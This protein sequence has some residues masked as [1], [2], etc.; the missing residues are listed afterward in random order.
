[1]Y[2]Y[3]S[4]LYVVLLFTYTMYKIYISSRHA[5]TIKKKLYAYLSDI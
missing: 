3:A 4:M 5:Q 1:M 2:H